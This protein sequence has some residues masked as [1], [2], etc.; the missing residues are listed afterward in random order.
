MT[1]LAE[2]ITSFRH[3]L[4]VEEALLLHCANRSL[5]PAGIAEAE[6]LLQEVNWERFL[7]LSYQHGVAALV[8]RRL[9][10]HFLALT[11]E[12]VVADLRRYAILNTQNNLGLLH[13]LVNTVDLLRE[14]C[15]KF[16]VF[17]G[18]VTAELGYGDIS[19]RRCNDI[20]ILVTGADHPRVK[21]LFLSEGF[22]RTMSSKSE[23][24]CVQSGLWHKGR[25]LKIDLHWGI[26]PRELGI[27]VNP[28]L[29]NGSSITLAGKVIPTFAKEDMFIILCTNAT[30]EFWQQQLYAYCDIS[31]FLQRHTDMNWKLIVTRARLLRCERVLL[32]ALSIVK[33]LFNSPLPAEIDARVTANASV[34]RVVCELLYQLFDHKIAYSAESRGGRRLY[35]FRSPSDY[36]STLIDNRV[37]RLTYK[38]LIS[39][40][41]R[42]TA[43]AQGDEPIPA[44]STLS[45]LSAATRSPRILGLVL[46][47]LYR[48]LV[49]FLPDSKR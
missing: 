40:L 6:N 38:A 13:E 8:F 5:P 15:I 9:N 44:T 21:A 14:Q 32:A 7:Q 46:L 30:K 24:L 36:F 11:P 1:M 17:K 42:V 19:I 41:L 33:A 26:P 27:E 4:P 20:D 49:A 35:Y 29:Q 47:K 18:L 23:F 28:I 10:S 37:A 31:E 16:A 39:R 2:T 48:E 45:L 22:E 43:D 25:M 34:Q 3:D 12:E